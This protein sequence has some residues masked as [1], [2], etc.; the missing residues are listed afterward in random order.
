M[1][2]KGKE[3]TLQ[4]RHQLLCVLKQR[5]S[6]PHHR[7]SP[8][9]AHASDLSRSSRGKSYSPVCSQRTQPAHPPSLECVRVLIPTPH[10]ASPLALGGGAGRQDLGVVPTRTVHMHSPHYP[11]FHIFLNP[12]HVLV[13]RPMLFNCASLMHVGAVSCAPVPPLWGTRP[14]CRRS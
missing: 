9:P 12:R 11:N 1:E 4:T 7:P 8:T 5:C 10:S 6:Q 2:P 13:E 14:P 3:L